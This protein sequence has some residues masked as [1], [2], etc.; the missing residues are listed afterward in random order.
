[1]SSSCSRRRKWITSLAAS[2]RVLYSASVL[3]SETVCCSLLLHEMLVFSNLWRIPDV[4]LRVSGSMPQSASAY[5]CRVPV[6][7]LGKNMP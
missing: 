4:D 7:V 3:E 6:P 2:V 1:M 5:V